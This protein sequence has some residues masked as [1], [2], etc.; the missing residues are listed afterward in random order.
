MV[1]VVAG[2]V[3]IVVVEE[4]VEVVVEIRAISAL[5]ET[6]DSP[7]AKSIL[8]TFSPFSVFGAC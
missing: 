6:V 4:V 5:L 1:Q 3:A 8:A 2:V 7:L